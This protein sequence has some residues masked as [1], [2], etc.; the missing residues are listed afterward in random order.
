MAKSTVDTLAA[1]IRQILEDYEGDIQNLTKETVKKIGNKGVQALKS[2]S[3][4]FGGTGKYKSG[5]SSRI[6]ETRTGAKAI[7]HNAKVPGLP[8]LLEYGHAKRGGGRVSGKIH[9]QPV[10]EE[11]EKAFTQELESGI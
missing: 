5:W 3:S 1:D 11:L 2:N 8:H 7:L 9:I 6:E 4:V 10:E